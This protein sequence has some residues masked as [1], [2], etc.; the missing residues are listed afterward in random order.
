MDWAKAKNILIIAFIITNLILG[1]YVF[2]DWKANNVSYSISEERIND[3]KKIL[4]KKNIIVNASVPQDIFELPGLILEYETYN[5]E[6]IEARVFGDGKRDYIQKV[7]VSLNDKLINYTKRTIE[8][9][10]EETTEETAKK[11]SYDFIKKLGFHN[12]EIEFWDIKQKNDEYEIQYKQ[13]YE[14]IILDDGY[15]KIGIKNNEVFSL[16]RKWLKS[17]TVKPI[18]KKVIPA[19]KALL[20]GMDELREKKEK[21][22][23]EVIVTDIKLVYSLNSPEF[24]SIFD[25]QWYEGNEKSGLFYWRIRLES[26]EDIDIKAEAYE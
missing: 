24:S 23:S 21:E 3:V 20:L 12:D 8:L 10:N 17:I 14:D 9:Y 2:K 11:I 1:Y 13:R 19:T 26:D 16:E 6:E 4:N 7:K 18:N 22:D 25:E 5:K 15:M